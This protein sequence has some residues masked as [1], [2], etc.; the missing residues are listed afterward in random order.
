MSVFNRWTP[1]I[2]IVLILI[3]IV[4]RYFYPLVP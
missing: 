4:Y 2:I 1:A 3:A